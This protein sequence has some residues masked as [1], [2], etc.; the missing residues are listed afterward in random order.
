MAEALT[1]I[2]EDENLQ[3]QFSENN[4]AQAIKFETNTIV[5]Q[6]ENLVNSVVRLKVKG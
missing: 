4:K 3:K 6:W 1:K 2:L 5:D